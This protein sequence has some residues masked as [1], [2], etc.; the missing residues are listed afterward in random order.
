MEEPL[1]RF[2][3]LYGTELGRSVVLYSVVRTVV[4]AENAGCMYGV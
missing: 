2:V 4:N 3:L 1:T